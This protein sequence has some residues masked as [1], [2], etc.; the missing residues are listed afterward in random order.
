M[1][2]LSSGLEISPFLE[3]IFNAINV[4]TVICVV[5]AF[6]DATPISG[7]ACVY[8]PA[9][10]S[11]AIEDPTTLQTPKTK[12]PFDFASFIA[13]KVS[14]VSP[15][16]EIAIITSFEVIIGFL[17][18]NSDAYSTSTGIRALS[19]I[20]YSPTKPACQ[21]VPQA[22]IIIRSAFTNLLI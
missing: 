13:A 14:A 1:N 9:F 4:K 17:Y 15:D 20:R 3:A 10:V 6:V 18:L 5:K 7:P 21:E 22:I 12:A 16:C 2:A 8:A 11:L 19:S